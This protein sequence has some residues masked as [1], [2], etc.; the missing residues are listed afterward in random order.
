MRIE[1]NYVREE[2]RDPGSDQILHNWQLILALLLLLLLLELKT[3]MKV[4][5]T[6]GITIV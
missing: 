5:T 1:Q 3:K 4:Y 2:L 6:G